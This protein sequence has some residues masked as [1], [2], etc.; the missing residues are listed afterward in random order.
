MKKG[1]KHHDSE[2]ER[3]HDRL[4]LEQEPRPQTECMLYH[5]AASSLSIPGGG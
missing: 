1:R 2:S 3:L 5:L 4:V